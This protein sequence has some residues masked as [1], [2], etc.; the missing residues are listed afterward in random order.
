MILL[1]LV[2]WIAMVI[3]LYILPDFILKV[4]RFDVLKVMHIYYLQVS[5]ANLSSI[6]LIQLEK[7]QKFPDLT[8]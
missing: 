3:D 5:L 6:K 4:Q 7:L 1:I 8:I 2:H